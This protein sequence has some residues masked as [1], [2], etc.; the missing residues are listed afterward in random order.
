[1]AVTTNVLNIKSTGIVKYDGAGT[2]SARSIP[3][4]VANGGTGATSHTAYAVLCGGTSST[5]A[6]QSI[7]SVGS[8]DQVL[9]SNGAAALPTF[10]AAP[11][12]TGIVLYRSNAN[13]VFPADATTYY[14]G[15]TWNTTGGLA[16]NRM[17]I[18]ASGTITDAYVNVTSSGASSEN[19]TAF[20][21]LNGTT[22]TNISTTWQWTSSDVLL[23]N[24]SLSTSVSAGDYI[25]FGIVTPAWSANPTNVD[26]S[27]SIFIG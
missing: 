6:V 15:D 10:K 1:M 24:N 3:L 12:G 20:Y 18:T 27:V 25:E 5:G 4:K 19:V 16:Q 11:T 9:T 14:I 21:K 26:I 13:N 8:A 23:T 22:T 17:Y 7:A 2:F